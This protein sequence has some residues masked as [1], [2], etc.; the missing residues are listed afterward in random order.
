DLLQNFLWRMPLGSITQMKRIPWLVGHNPDVALINRIAAK[1]HVEPDFLLQH[2]HQLSGVVVS[3]EEFLAI[4]QSIDVLPSATCARF[5]LNDFVD[6][7]KLRGNVFA[8]GFLIH[9]PDKRRRKTVFLS[10]KY[11]DFFHRC[12]AVISSEARGEVEK[13]LEFQTS[14]R[15]VS[16]SLDMTQTS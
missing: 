15:D 13:P 8:A 12:A 7:H 4:V 11:S 14:A 5:A 9:P 6:P 10:K 16:T 3:A 1:I 2:H